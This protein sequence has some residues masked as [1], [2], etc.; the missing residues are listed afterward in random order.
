MRKRITLTI[1]AALLGLASILQILPAQAEPYTVKEGETFYSIAKNYNMSVESVLSA[2]PTINP[3]NL[4]GGLSIELPSPVVQ[5][6]VLEGMP[7]NN[8][9][10]VAKMTNRQ[11]KRLRIIRKQ[12][13]N[14]LLLK[15]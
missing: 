1:T 13:Y 8:A 5:K 6:S 14:K 7:V 9:L 11:S 12:Q 4:Y 10:G 3:K 2:N 15:M